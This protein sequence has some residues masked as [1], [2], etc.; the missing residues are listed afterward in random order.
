MSRVHEKSIQAHL[1][2]L[3]ELL[4][5]SGAE[6]AAPAAAY[7]ALVIETFERDGRLLMCGNGGSAATVEHVATEYV[8]RLK[9]ERRALPAIALTAGTAQLT[10]SANDYGYEMAFVRSLRAFGRRGDL[11]VMHSTSGESANL[12]AAAAEASRMEAG[13]VA[14]LGKGGGPLAELVDLPIRVP[15][16]DTA[17]VQ[18]VHLAIEHAVAD[19]VDAHF[20]GGREEQESSR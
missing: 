13:T 15:E 11:V 1:E 9:R 20:A 3:S 18:E 8:V 14:L 7:A 4:V 10:A 17:R 2:A 6:I 16:R 12:L 19:I 5:R